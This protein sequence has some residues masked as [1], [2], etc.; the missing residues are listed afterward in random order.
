LSRTAI[1]TAIFPLIFAS[2]LS[3]QVTQEWAR[4]Y[5]GNSVR[6]EAHAM[7]VDTSGNVYVTGYYYDSTGVMDF[8]TIKYNSSG[9]QQWVQKYN[10]PGNDDDYSKFIAVDASGNVYVSG[11][12][13]G[14]GTGL[15]YTTIK[16]NTDG[17][18]QWIQRYNGTE[19]EDDEVTDMVIDA[20]GNVYVTGYCYDTVPG[21][22]I[23]DNYY[24]TG[25]DFTTI[26]YNSNGQELWV[27]KF[28]EPYTL[29]PGNDFAEAMTVDNSGNVYVT[30]RS[31]GM[32]GTPYGFLWHC[33]TIKYDSFGDSVWVQRYNMST[34]SYSQIVPSKIAVN[35]AGYVFVTGSC[36]FSDDSGQDYFTLKY[37]SDG[38]FQWMETYSGAGKNP[39]AP[40][41]I[42][43]D[44]NNVYVTGLSTGS[45]SG[46][47]YATVKYNF[48]GVQQWVQTYNGP[49][50]NIDEPLSMK[51][52]NSGYIYVTGLSVR[53]SASEIID[54]AT[55]KYDYYGNQKWL[56]RYTGSLSAACA[57][58]CLAVD[59][60]YNVFVAGVADGALTTIKY[61]QSATGVNP[62]VSGL[63]KDYSLS[64]NY[65]N[66]FNPSTT[67]RYD[68]PKAGMVLL[69][70]YDLLGKEVSTLVNEYK[71]A[72]SYNV[73]FNAGNLSSGI[74]F[75]SLTSGNF[76]QIKKLVFEK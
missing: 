5:T 10:G 56:A 52:D 6:A 32:G 2:L 7:A 74:Y 76:T 60:Y 18:Q 34:N 25:R 63:P 64:Q 44:D 41:A 69:K 3:A 30:G 20:S 72:G 61:S 42:A 19:N 22:T 47:D 70:V 13:A 66:P 29:N 12:S 59:S 14:D 24:T 43:V 39:D 28:I 48:S 68:L 26:K 45:T 49:A 46:Y 62:T 54:F 16:Y 27:K 15:D 50:N 53:D 55:I 75:Y 9:T 65:P 67:I 1:I 37:S 23:S 73:E 36:Y 40:T 31:M 21:F 71:S 38:N 33:V 51:I 58:Y 11:Y 17:V 4:K 57:G 35:S 8:V